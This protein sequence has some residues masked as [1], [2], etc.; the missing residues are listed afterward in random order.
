MLKV[1]LSGGRKALE[2]SAQAL[3]ELMST[4]RTAS[5]TELAGNWG[6]MLPRSADLVVERMQHSYLDGV[7]LVSDRQPTR[8]MA[9]AW[10]GLSSTLASVPGRSSPISFGHELGDVLANSW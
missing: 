6:H 1:S 9:A 7:R 2:N 4:T 10:R 3:D 5:P 8:P